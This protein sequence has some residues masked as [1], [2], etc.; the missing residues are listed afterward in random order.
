MED[1]TKYDDQIDLFSTFGNKN[2]R[3]FVK[4]EGLSLP[5]NLLSLPQTT[6]PLTRIDRQSTFTTPENSL[7]SSEAIITTRFSAPG[8]RDTG[9]RGFLDIASGEKSVYN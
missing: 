5:T 8:S 7:T 1:N 4:A 6:Q 9:T 3:T 2:K